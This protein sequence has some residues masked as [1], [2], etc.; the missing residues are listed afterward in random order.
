[1][2]KYYMFN[3]PCGCI[4]ARRDERHK[5]VMEYFKDLA[6][7]NLA[8]VGRL[9]KETEGLLFITDDGMF[10]QYMTHPDY[11]ITKVY[12]FI[13]M[14]VLTEEN[15]KLLEEGVYITGSEKKTAPCTVRLTGTGVLKDVLKDLPEE[16]R[17]KTGHNRMDHP[18]FTAEIS[19]AEGRK[20]QIRR[21]LKSVGCLII[22]LKR[23]CADGIWLDENLQP[24]EWK[25]FTWEGKL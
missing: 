12:S 14:G 21:M 2:Y 6:N 18:V 19:L 17:R 13:A 16:I 20:R 5:T 3:K 24:G 11:G 1:M 10:N 25:E 9:D 7:P 23:I 15:R 22:Y 4:T 8:P